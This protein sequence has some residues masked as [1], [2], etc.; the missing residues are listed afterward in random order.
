MSAKDACP[1]G[2]GR[3]YR[4][5][6]GPLHRG[7]RE[8]SDAEALMR[9]RYAAFARKEIDYLYRTL[10]PEHED[11]ARPEADVLRDLRATASTLRYMGLQILDRRAPDE[12]GIARVLFLARIFE[13]GRERSFVELSEF[14]HDG[15]G[16]RYLR[17]EARP[18]ARIAGDPA[19][20]RIDSFSALASR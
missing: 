1:C 9:S 16:W 12:A 2:N 5:C 18:V 15:E 3:P 19:A 4:G 7:E 20:I 14:A 6:C 10:H 11:R 17:G 13:K 8:A